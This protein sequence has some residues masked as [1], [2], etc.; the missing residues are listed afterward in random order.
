MAAAAVD[1]GY[2]A[3]S[4]AVP[5]PTLHSLLDAPT[6]E[7]VQALLAHIQAKAHE[8]DEVKAEKLRSDVELENALH[9]GE[10]RARALKASADKALKDVDDLRQKLVQEEASREQVETELQNLKSSASSSTS[11]VQALESRIKTLESQNRDTV[12][13]HDSK[14]AQYDRLSDELSTQHQKFVKL[15]KEVS[16]LEE[17]NQS[18]EN[19]V[20][21]IKFRESTMQQ[22]IRRLKQD[23]EWYEAEMKTRAD[24]QADIRKKKNAK[25]AEL[26]RALADANQAR[27]TLLRTETSQ[28]QRIS[29]LEQKMEDSLLR[30][31]QMQDAAAQEQEAARVRLDHH[32]RLEKL[33][34]EKAKSA[35]NR[36]QEME[37]D[38]AHVKD[39]AA[40]EVGLLQA[41]VTSERTQREA[42][43]GKIAELELQIENLE[44]Q[45]TELRVAFAAPA[46]PRRALNGGF[47]TPRAGSPSI[48][49]PSRGKGGMTQTQLYSENS[50]LRMK[51]R[52]L[53]EQLDETK[54]TLQEMLETLEPLQPELD[55]LRQENERLLSDNAQMSDLLEEA[56][57]GRE[58]A[59]RDSRKLQGDSKGLRREADILRQQLR[60]SGTQIRVL[61]LL[62]QV[63]AHG[64][65]SLSDADKEYV[66]RVSRNDIPLDPS[67]HLTDTGRLISQHLVVFKNIAEL[68]E[69]NERNLRQIRALGDQYEGTEAQAKANQVEQDQQQLAQLRDTLAQREEEVRSLKLR[70]ESLVKERD[71]Y[72]RV[73]TSRGQVH[74]GS[75]AGSIF[76][77]SIDGRAAVTPPPGAFSQSVEQTPRSKE[78]AEY[79]NLVKELQNHADFLKSQYNETETSY[80]LQVD[81]LTKEINEASAERFRL[82]NSNQLA[83]ERYELLQSKLDLLKQ[84]N[85]ELVKRSNSLQDHAAKQD[86]QVQ[87]AAEQLVEANSAKDSLQRE[88]SNLKASQGLSKQIEERL[89]ADNDRLLQDKSTLQLEINRLRSDEAE[90]RLRFEENRRRLE[91]KG[92]SLETE[93]HNLK[94]KLE[95]EHEEQ[96]KLAL[97]REYE[98]S[99]TR[100]KVDDLTK[101][102]NNIRPEL[103]SLRTERD[104]LQARVDELKVELHIAQD[105]AQ[106]LSARPTPRANG[107][108]D[109]SGDEL[110]REEELSVEISNL[111][112]E[113]EGA[114]EELE[115][116]KTDIERY[117]EIS[118]GAEES[119]EAER[120]AHEHYVEEMD[121]VITEKD[122]RIRDLEQR[123]EETSAEYANTNNELTELRDKHKADSSRFANEKEL[124]QSE[125]DRLKDEASREQEKAGLLQD[126]LKAQADIAS[127]AQQNYE[128]ELLQHSEAMQNLRSL[129]EQHN[130]LKTEVAQIKAQGDAAR[131]ALSQNEDIW[132]ETRGRYEHELEESR[133]RYREVNEQNKI[134]HRQIENVNSQIASL[135][136]NRLS[137]A[138][139]QQDAAP[140]DGDTEGLHE[141]IKYLRREKEIVDVQYELSIQDAKRLK[142]QLDYTISQ[143]DQARQQLSAEQ[144]SQASSRQNAASLESLQN[145]VEQLNL[146]RESATTLRNE[147]RQ[148]QTRLTQKTKEL[149]DLNKQIE[150]LNSRVTELEGELESKTR[151][152][153][154]L[155][156]DRD[157]WQ[158]RHQDVLQ[159]YD[160]IDPAELEALKTEIETLTTERDEAQEKLGGFDARLT[161]EKDTAVDELK[162]DYEARREKMIGQF[163]ERSKM[164]SGQIKE[165]DTTNQ[166]LTT[167]RDQLH[168]QLTS[169]QQELDVA[170]QERDSAQQ[171]LHTTRQELEVANN[172][173]D[174]ALA[175]ANANTSSD[176]AMAEEGQVE[177]NNAGLADEE[178]QSLV[179]RAEAA[180]QRSFE[181]S[182]RSTALHIKAQQAEEQVGKLETQVGEL[183]QRIGTLSTE[184]SMAKEQAAQAAT[185]SNNVQPLQTSEPSAV[186][187]PE[188]NAKLKEELQEIKEELATTK[189]QLAASQKEAEDAKTHADMQTFASG[190]A[191]ETPASADI[192]EVRADAEK[193][194]KEAQEKYEGRAENMKK[195]YNSKLKETRQKDEDGRKQLQEQLHA[196]HE[197]NMQRLASEHEVNI[198]RLTTEHQAELNRIRQEVQPTA[199][200]ID[201]SLAATETSAVVNTVPEPAVKAEAS[202]PDEADE[203]KVKEFISN[204]K[205][206]QGIIKRNIVQQLAKEKTTAQQQQEQAVAQKL[207]EAKEDMKTQILSEQEPATKQKVEEA[208]GKAR[209]EAE[210][211]FAVQ[212]NMI[213]NRIAGATAKLAVVETA[214]K[215]TPEK[216]VKEVWEVASKAKPPPKEKAQPPQSAQ[217]KPVPAAP[218][219]QQSQGATNAQVPHTTVPAST[220]ASSAIPHTN[221]ASNPFGQ[222]AF[223]QPQQSV[224]TN[225]FGQPKQFNQQFNQHSGQPLF[226]Q[227]AAGPTAFSALAQ[228]GFIGAPQQN[229]ANNVRP[230]SPFNQQQPQP[231]Q[232]GR[233]R[234]ENAGTGPAALR[235][236][237]GQQGGPT[238]IPRGGG[239]PRPSGRGQGQPNQ[240]NQGQGNINVQ[241]AGASQL[242]R[243]GGRGRGG[244]GGGQIQTNIPA[245]QAPGQNSPRSMNPNAQQFNPGSSG[246]RGQ[247]R[248]REDAPEAEGAGHQG[249][250]RQRGGAGGGA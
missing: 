223:G 101:A 134:L 11:E 61:L 7:L 135:K 205:V 115:S 35:L 142:Q 86:I 125:I 180:E 25:I 57:Q 241:G 198:Q 170:R 41:E 119:L 44:S 5:E 141:V 172:A 190:A 230:N 69:Q 153:G 192:A 149:E 84:E 196:E 107:T 213:E 219:V 95:E 132:N 158:K 20:T 17:K 54:A 27:D 199:A 100:K 193:K 159:K 68:Q 92:T 113:L 162:K 3:A 207:E 150:P 51:N 222:P 201:Q 204:S 43:E 203:G 98:Q 215:E 139:G 105:R 145:T 250:K 39:E 97:R 117:R 231:P 77:Q 24:E 247:K 12:A 131:S 140:S 72:K 85:N 232:A 63:K 65:D 244:R 144:L 154:V 126:D 225:P 175:N 242:G 47:G 202:L 114:R 166:A 29:E 78:N 186:Q 127:R 211:K 221:G 62:D 22:E 55:E 209:E 248:A 81:R 18:L 151:E 103:A 200:A 14:S 161:A 176:T 124:L 67:E 220:P 90:E 4:Y 128:N 49:T 212:R 64:L 240:Q 152:A 1:V 185:Q 130:Q 104:Q 138:G 93:L 38:L 9:G 206:A 160:R 56:V 146:Y 102:L 245:G 82:Q 79:A 46:T 99:E 26:E 163:K 136:Q 96:R 121:R 137:V 116:A 168:Q 174:E 60:D 16:E 34:E 36:V 224:Q 106:T 214:A 208:R 71:M 173:R 6:V 179:A 234:G 111:K 73:A 110:S 108:A 246:G 118:Q 226:G 182:N 45:A 42:A 183:Q 191:E 189:E 80:K 87:Q 216:P 195:A 188:E 66:D 156:E 52:S 227:S 249:G 147:A 31:Q 76:G 94:Q 228:P 233:G 235:G 58:L 91:S 120:E 148:A 178:R 28:R 21:S 30:I 74:A 89:T 32:I 197:A 53:Q 122:E 165:K 88:N 237:I 177:E 143:L 229:P 70:S 48:A 83:N 15:R 2:L 181:E 187:N 109:A 129:R 8:F 33:Q 194:I 75:D 50:E 239:I 171:E 218:A 19:T 123:L 238:G 169:L 217:P 10:T 157:R 59:R 23:N 155:K 236:I 184:L 37:A 210:K 112:Q 243:G 13:L 167:E 40:D 133:K 164:L